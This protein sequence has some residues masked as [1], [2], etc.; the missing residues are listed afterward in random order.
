MT[1]SNLSFFRLL[2]LLYSGLAAR[3]LLAVA[4]PQTITTMRIE[5]QSDHPHDLFPFVPSFF[6][7]TIY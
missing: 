1:T 4:V 5:R 3:V 2:T 6:T 7:I